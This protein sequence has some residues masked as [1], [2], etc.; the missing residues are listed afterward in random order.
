MP[1]NGRAPRP[2]VE[3][4][5]PREDGVPASAPAL[6]TEP[7]PAAEPR[8]HPFAALTD[9]KLA[10]MLVEDPSALGPLSIGLPNAGALIGG[11]QMPDGARWQVVNPRETW[12][13]SETIEFLILCI[14]EV[15]EEFPDTL[16]IPIGDIGKPEGGALP[17][18]LSHQSGR[19]V[20]VGYYYTTGDKWYTPARPNNLDL[21]RT[22]A[23]VRAMVTRTDVEVI[24]IDRSIQKLLRGYAEG[25]GEDA[26]WLD[27]LFGGPASALRALIR[28]EPGHRTHIH[29][30]F[31]NPIAQESGRRMYRLLLAHE[32]IEPPTYYVHYTAKR[33]DTLLRVARKLGTSVAAIK[34]A[35]GLRSNR[36]FAK[37]TY[38]IPRRGGVTPASAPVAIPPRRLPPRRDPRPS[39]AV[40][41]AAGTRGWR[42]RQAV[43][44]RSDMR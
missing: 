25:I 36:I 23:L 11:M 4:A 29:V 12:G 15:N 30:R 35:N 41:T 32:R 28:H 42:P 2:P 5:P 13:T 37:R 34:R 26:T 6:A 22:W 27:D 14:D 33:G 38:R 20:D 24:F 21:P 3:E 7:V 8:P 19:D 9:E 43:A 16:P 18:H 39:P 40:A 10:A 44:A 17:P 31:Y 1:W